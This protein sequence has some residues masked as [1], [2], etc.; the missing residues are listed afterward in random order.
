MTAQ[1]LAAAVLHDRAD[2][3]HASIDA[4]DAH[5]N[6]CT[7]NGWCARREALGRARHDAYQ[8]ALD[9]AAANRRSAS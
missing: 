8:S 4:H 7:N 6:N 9:T 3:L 1:W 5:R 2:A